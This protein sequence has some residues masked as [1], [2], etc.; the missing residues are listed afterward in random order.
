LPS[1]QQSTRGELF[2]SFRT[3]YCTDLNA[4]TKPP[5]L[6]HKCQVQNG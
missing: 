1:N 3:V 5:F 4:Q 2:S 6:P